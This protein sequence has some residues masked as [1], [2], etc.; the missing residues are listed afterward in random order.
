MFRLYECILTRTKA[1]LSLRIA[2]LA[3]NSA[4]YNHTSLGT[5][6]ETNSS[7]GPIQLQKSYQA[8]RRVRKL[9]VMHRITRHHQAPKTNGHGSTSFEMLPRRCACRDADFNR[10]ATT[11]TQPPRSSLPPHTQSTLAVNQTQ[12]T[13]RSSLIRK[14]KAEN[15]RVPPQSIA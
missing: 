13:F 3:I 4:G 8:V 7:G 10:A 15:Q 2:C 1:H 14:I 6:I 9:L 11:H 12:H 5:H